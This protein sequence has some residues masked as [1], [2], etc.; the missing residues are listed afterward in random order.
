MN[1]F[2]LFKGAGLVL[3]LI[4]IGSQPAHAQQEKGDKEVLFFSGN[5]FIGVG[6]TSGSSGATLGGGLGYF[7]TR[8]NEV[9]G[10]LT[11]SVSR[12]RFCV[13]RVGPGGI[14]V[15]DCES[16][17]DFGLG[18]T[19]FYRYNFAGK[20]KRGFPF[21]GAELIVLDVT[22]NF[23]GNIRARPHIG[24]KYFVKKNV[25]IDFNVG[26]T[27]EL[28]KVEEQFFNRG[29]QGLIDGRVGLSFIF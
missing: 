17:T 20:D 21:V 5:F 7:L 24:Y 16:S 12:F 19:G 6:E 11:A 3:A 18:L 8:K 23:T 15:E 26:Y 13:A 27:V 1:S 2:R 29:R 25:A 10:A 4:L 22:E 14:I 28:N 9:G